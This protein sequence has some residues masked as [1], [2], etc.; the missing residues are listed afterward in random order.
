MYL[1]DLLNFLAKASCFLHEIMYGIY[2]VYTS[3]HILF[4]Y[5]FFKESIC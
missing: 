1:F 5:L 2:A 3:M 4:I